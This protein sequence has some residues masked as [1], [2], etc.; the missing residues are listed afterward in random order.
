[1]PGDAQSFAAFGIQGPAPQWFWISLTGYLGEGGQTALRFE[2]E[3]EH[4]EAA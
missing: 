2:M 3:Y 4:R 1:M